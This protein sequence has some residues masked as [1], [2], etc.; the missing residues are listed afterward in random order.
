MTDAR[1][2]ASLKRLKLSTNDAMQSELKQFCAQS[3][4]FF[5]SSA[6]VFRN[7]DLLPANLAS[8]RDSIA[9]QRL[10]D[11]KTADKVIGGL[12]S[13]SRD[14]KALIRQSQSTSTMLDNLRNQV[15]RLTSALMLIARDIKEILISLQAFS[16]DLS[17]MILA[18]GY[19]EL[20]SKPRCFDGLL[21]LIIFLKE[22]I[23][24]Y[25]SNDE[26][27]RPSC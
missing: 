4:D 2:R 5:T 12:D 19:V 10:K 16:K 20:I 23:A 7:L 14:S 8:L 24:R 26:E 9:E 17:E 25:P 13:I 27:T 6:T 15:F 21:K 11:S 18:N 3:Q 1:C 22:E